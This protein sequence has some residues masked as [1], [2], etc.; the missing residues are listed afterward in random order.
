[1]GFVGLASMMSWASQGQALDYP[2]MCRGGEGMWG[3]SR[4]WSSAHRV[5]L[6]FK[7]G[8][9]AANPRNGECVWIDRAVS[10]QEPNKLMY[11]TTATSGAQDYL[12]TPGGIMSATGPIKLFLDGVRPG[13]VFY[14]RAENN[15]QGL[16]IIN[17]LGP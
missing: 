1:M 12:L 5:E 16:F 10:A 17:R 3:R 4:H 7:R 15:G 11:T 9:V 8:T 2:L 6:N 13:Q 14:V